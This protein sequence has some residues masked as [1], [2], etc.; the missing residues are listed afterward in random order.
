MR[1]VA[2]RGNDEDIA[3]PREWHGLFERTERTTVETNKFRLPPLRPAVREVALHAPAD[4]AR[5]LEFSTRNPDTTSGDVHQP[6]RMIS[7]EVGEHDV[8]HVARADAPR[9]QLR[10]EFLVGMH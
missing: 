1:C 6:S 7:V 10:S 2:W 5:A 8:S 3:A 4:A 9:A